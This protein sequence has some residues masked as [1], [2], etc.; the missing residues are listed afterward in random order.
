M[1]LNG[2]K[3]TIKCTLICMIRMIYMLCMMHLKYTMFSLNFEKHDGLP[4]VIWQPSDSLTLHSH[5]SWQCPPMGPGDVMGCDDVTCNKPQEK[6]YCTSG[7]VFLASTSPFT[8]RE[9]LLLRPGR[10]CHC[11]HYNTA[12]PR[13]LW[14]TPMGNIVDN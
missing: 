3:W 14:G 10:A 2:W 5:W 4:Q 6:C 12:S 13:G 9:D 8:P 1:V 7:D 11:T